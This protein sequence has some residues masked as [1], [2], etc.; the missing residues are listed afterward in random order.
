MNTNKPRVITD[1]EKLDNSIQDRLFLHYPDGFSN[2]LIEFKNHMNETIKALPFET[3][4]KMYLIRMS[5]K[6]AVQIVED[7]ELDD[8]LEDDNYSDDEFLTDDDDD[9]DI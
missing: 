4:E 7:A 9:D 3:E 1:F 6:E 2:H 5:K 8:D